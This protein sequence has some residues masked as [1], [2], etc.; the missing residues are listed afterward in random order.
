M[1]YTLKD[2]SQIESVPI[3]QSSVKIGEIS[4][5][6][7][8]TVCDRG[9]A[10]SSG[11]GATVICKC[12]CGKYTLLKLQAFRDGTTKSC[13]CYNKKV[14]Q[15]LC[16]EIGKKQYFKDYSSPDLNINPYYNFISPTEEITPLGVKWIIKCKKCGKE[17]I[18]VPN[19]LISDKRCRGN[20]PCSCWKQTSKGVLKLINLLEEMNIQ[21]FTEY[22]FPTCLS[23]KNNPLKFDFYLPEQDLLIEYDG[24]QHFE[25]KGMFGDKYHEQKF[26]LQQEYDKIKNDW[27]LKNNKKLIRISYKDYNNINQHYIERILN[28]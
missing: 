26:K 9:P 11:R 18:E 22:S 2:G 13:G 27:C 15:K 10:P 21:Y 25:D 19:Q 12:R 28:E 23:I 16:K 24:E 7:M 14:H 6:G 4:P 5:N 3:G 1:L 17:F 20:N 8:L